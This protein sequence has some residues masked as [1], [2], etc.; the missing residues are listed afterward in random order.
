MKNC[1]GKWRGKGREKRKEREGPGLRLGLLI[2]IGL[3]PNPFPPSPPL[4]PAHRPLLIPHSLILPPL[5]L[6]SL[7][8]FPIPTHRPLISSPSPSP[9]PY[10]PFPYS[11]SSASPYSHLSAPSHSL[12]P[13]PI[14][15]S[16]STPWLIASPS[17]SSPRHNLSNILKTCKYANILI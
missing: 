3:P 5:P 11:C 14:P 8:L 12:F 16:L 4:I 15:G 9:S 2:L 13:I 10:S 17:L 7:P 1:R 6:S